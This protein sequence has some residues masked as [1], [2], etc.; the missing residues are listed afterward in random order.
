MDRPDMPEFGTAEG[1]VG[2]LGVVDGPYPPCSLCGSKGYPADLEIT[3][4]GNDAWVCYECWTS[5][6]IPE[7]VRT[8]A[9]VSWDKVMRLRATPWSRSW[10]G[11]KRRSREDAPDDKQP[12]LRLP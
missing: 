1:E 11:W 8:V 9:P 5:D 2:M 3:M 6:K 4:G 12:T 10:R 7:A